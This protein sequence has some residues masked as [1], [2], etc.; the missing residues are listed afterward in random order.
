MLVIYF[1]VT[2]LFWCCSLLHCSRY[3]YWAFYLY[4]SK[5]S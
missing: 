2:N 1:L 4:F 3:D 5:F